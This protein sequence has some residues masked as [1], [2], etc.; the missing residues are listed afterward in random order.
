MSRINGGIWRLRKED[1]A[2]KYSQN[3]SSTFGSRHRNGEE[4]L[5]RIYDVLLSPGQRTLGSEIEQSGATDGR[6]GVY[7]GHQRIR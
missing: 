1:V 4:L 3:Y 2:L 7:L 5:S 6:R